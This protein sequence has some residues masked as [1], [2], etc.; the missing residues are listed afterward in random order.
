MMNISSGLEH[1]VSK[2]LTKSKRERFIGFLSN[3]KGHAKF[4]KALDHDF[5][6]SL[7]PVKFA[8]KFSSK[9]L[10]QAGDLYC[11]N[12]VTNN[13][14]DSMVNLYGKAPCQGDWMLLNKPGTIAIYRPEGR[15]DGELYIRL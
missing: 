12:G 6:K 7:D 15:I 13:N 1:F 14:D 2:A 8:S 5:E 9:E 4:S 11:S 10:E 3:A